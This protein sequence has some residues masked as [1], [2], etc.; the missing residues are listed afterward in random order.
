MHYAL[1]LVA[2][3]IYLA[4]AALVS[5]LGGRITAWEYVA[6]GAEATFLWAFVF[7]VLLR[8]LP[9]R[10]ARLLPLAIAAWACLEGAE[11]AVCR[12]MLPMDQPLVIGDQTLCEAAIGYSVTWFSIVAAAFIAC[13]AQE[14]LKWRTN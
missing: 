14:L 8:A 4:P 3:L 12:V 9:P 7:Y 1:L 2:A 13:F 6:W 11:R 10:A 5:L